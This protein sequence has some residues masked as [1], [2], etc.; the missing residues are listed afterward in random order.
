MLTPA[1]DLPASSVPNGRHRAGRAA[2]PV[3]RPL[4]WAAAFA[5]GAAGVAS[6]A[7]MTPAA[8]QQLDT[9]LNR[10]RPAASASASPPAP[11]AEPAASPS[12]VYQAGDDPAEAAAAAASSA[13]SDAAGPGL[14]LA[15]RLAPP[16]RGA[17]AR[18]LPIYFEADRLSGVAA[19]HTRAE[20]TA[21]LKRGDLSIRADV[22]EHTEADNT[23]RAI[24][25]V[26]VNR[27]G[28]IYSGPQLQ[29]QLDTYAGYFESP[30]YRFAL[31]GAG[32]QAERIDFIDADHAVATGATYTSCV[33][34]EG[35]DP[36]WILSA[37]RVRMD[38]ENK[39][40][41]AEGAVVRF[42]GVPIVG[43]PV[44][45]F[46]LS[47]DRK[48]GWLPPTFDVNS[49]SGFELAVPYYWNIAPNYDATITPTYAA[50]RG[51]GLN[52]EFRYLQPGWSGQ[53][54]AD[55]LPND[56]E[57]GRSRWLGQWKHSA[58]FGT[59]TDASVNLLRVSD[60]D[61]WKDYPR[62]IPS[63]T[64]RLL[65]SDA[66]VEHRLAD[67]VLGGLGATSLATYAAVQSW[68]V[69]Q[70][71]DVAD[72][73]V[74]PY[75][76]LPQLGLR[77]LGE[78]GGAGLQWSAETEINRFALSDRIEDQGRPVGT[79]V[80]ALVGIARPWQ[81]LADTPGWVI[82]PRLLLNA[83]SYQ[84]DEAMSDGRTQASR[85]IPTASIDSVWQLERDS[86][87]FGRAY[88]Q[89]LEPRIKYVHTP[90]RDQSALPVFDS[91][92]LDFNADN[93][94]AD[95]TF[96]G[97]D[98]VADLHQVIAGVTTRLV[99]Q[100]TGAEA[101]RLG[102]VQR[103]LLSDQR[104]TEDGEPLTQRLSDLLLLGSTSVIPHWWVDATAQFSS[105]DN[106]I[107]RSVMGVRYS[108]GA[109]RTIGATYRLTRD[110][111]EQIDLGWQWPVWGR[112]PPLA[113]APAGQL[114]RALASRSG[115]GQCGRSTLYSV[116]RVSYS[117]QDSRITDSL[118]GFE[119]DAGCW[120][121]RVVAE[122][123]STGQSEA[124]TRL[125]FQLELVGLSRLGSSPLGALRDNI[126]GY[127]LLRD[128][129]A[130]A[131][132]PEPAEPFS[133]DD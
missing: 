27:A 66:R 17:A 42:L 79:R 127:R 87:W 116:G 13:A 60:D 113:D 126:P 90:Y 3:V 29:M 100:A 71:V 92:A 73:L 72:R 55:T 95:N 75:R 28:D 65:S 120:I 117:L 54:R 30:T 78:L 25:N 81:P 132:P 106:R 121:G 74:A 97:I 104:I 10:P 112:M 45:S 35:S 83:A 82:T 99:D 77:A 23:A 46:P 44:L 109:W 88:T 76:R 2:A 67:G 108:P 24:G 103:Y 118:F 40:G 1:A 16:P 9:T 19:G 125:M 96:S 37:R 58:A 63:L 52:T 89:T 47:E 22:L 64:R 119:Y 4:A 130:P 33:P 39:V 15:P 94:F 124:T 107:Q 20:G 61:Y 111:S 62:E 51:V 31:T 56:A 34:D 105:D 84:T 70:D 98:R 43:V 114:T 26:R 122:R 123:I 129:A 101:L 133:T 49:R 8:A 86:S 53:L 102:I 93:I 6:L 69:L 5:A 85:L 131:A 7:G 18:E 12:S 48:S 68:Q 128:E 11:T 57:A 41:V 115:S 110:A 21:R 36:D 38:F 59:R 80:H 14:R 32:G 91:A 50:R